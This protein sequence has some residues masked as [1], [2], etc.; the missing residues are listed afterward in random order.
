MTMARIHIRDFTLLLL[1][2][3]FFSCT[4]STT[5]NNPSNIDSVDTN[6][7][8]KSLL[9][10]NKKITQRVQRT[11]IELLHERATVMFL[12]VAN[13]SSSTTNKEIKQFFTENI[14][15][16]QDSQLN[17]RPPIPIKNTDFTSQ[18]LYYDSYYGFVGNT[19]DT[20]ATL[21]SLEVLIVI[22]SYNVY[23]KGEAIN[24][25]YYKV[26]YENRTQGSVNTDKTFSE[27]EIIKEVKKLDL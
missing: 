24:G 9:N 2:I 4:E 26:T 17:D 3:V 13:D 7:A 19:M 20:V 27:K 15:T 18:I 1:M 5:I 16:S 12:A 22:S 11:D 10:Q 6:V 23:R 25:L 8:A 14:E 21:T